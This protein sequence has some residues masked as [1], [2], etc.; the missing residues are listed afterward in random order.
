M[1]SS[2]VFYHHDLGRECHIFG[3]RVAGSPSFSVEQGR[4]LIRIN[5]EQITEFLDALHEAEVMSDWFR[6]DTAVFLEL[7]EICF[8]CSSA[9]LVEENAGNPPFCPECES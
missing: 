1:L 3:E 5:E 2:T 9:L 6:L 4:G 7:D 8:N